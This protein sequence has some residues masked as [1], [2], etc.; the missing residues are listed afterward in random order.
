MN[1]IHSD[2]IRLIARVRM[3]KQI[4][5]RLI[6]GVRCCLRTLH[7]HFFT[8]IFLHEENLCEKKQK[9]Y[10]PQLNP[11][12]ALLRKLFFVEEGNNLNLGFYIGIEYLSE[13]LRISHF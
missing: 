3:L 9:K 11:P 6:A 1:I 7:T 10:N 8:Q 2:S 5:F 4:C 13:K 12:P